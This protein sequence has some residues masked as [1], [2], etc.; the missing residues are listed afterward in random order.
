MSQGNG[1]YG[2]VKGIPYAILINMEKGEVVEIMT[3][4]TK[5]IE[6]C[7][8]REFAAERFSNPQITKTHKEQFVF[9]D[10]LPLVDMK[11][12][13]RDYD[14]V[15]QEPRAEESQNLI[16]NDEEAREIIEGSMDQEE[17][18]KEPQESEIRRKTQDNRVKQR[19]R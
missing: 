10:R 13:M 17:I 19:K 7:G 2:A 6:E 15:N 9:D 11:G 5:S 12:P 16:N 18:E 14:S 1:E 4:G 8:G 3:L